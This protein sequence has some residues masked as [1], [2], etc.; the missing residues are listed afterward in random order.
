MW[1]PH[2]IEAKTLLSEPVAGCANHHH[3][4]QTAHKE[5]EKKR[6]QISADGQKTRSHLAAHLAASGNHT[7]AGFYFLFYYQ[8]A[9]D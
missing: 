5:E 2:E 3:Q 7:V 9:A 4:P 6:C 1:D 8:F